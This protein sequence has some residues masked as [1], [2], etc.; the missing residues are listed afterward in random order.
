MERKMTKEIIIFCMLI[1]FSAQNSYSK[2]KCSPEIAK[3]YFSSSD[4]ENAYKYLESCHDSSELTGLSYGQKG[5]LVISGFGEYPSL[6]IR[7]EVGFN[8][9][10]KSAAYGSNDGLNTLISFFREG[11]EFLH[12]EKDLNVVS[13][14]QKTEELTGAPRVKSVYACLPSKYQ[15]YE[16]TGLNR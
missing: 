2:E 7:M 8:L 16:L 12:I 6:L 15:I 4:L 13:C 11:E 1:L 3:S 9:F 14:L 10:I 5:Y